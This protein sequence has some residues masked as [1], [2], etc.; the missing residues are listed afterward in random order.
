MYGYIISLNPF[1][2]IACFEYRTGIYSSI[3][4]LRFGKF[5]KQMHKKPINPEDPLQ[6]AHMTKNLKMLLM[7]HFSFRLYIRF[8]NKRQTHLY[9]N[10]HKCT[11]NQ[12]LARRFECV[13]LDRLKGYTDLINL[14]ERSYQGKYQYATIYMRTNGTNEFNE[15]CRQY[16]TKGELSFVND[17]VIDE[18]NQYLKLFYTIQNGRVEIHTT[19]PQ[20]IDFKTIL[21]QKLNDK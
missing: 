18:T 17:P 1:S 12:L 2:S 11:Y 7:P 5:F 15:V 8:N 3:S 19:D 4:R 6:Q 21:N 16:N 9:G 14:I 13:Q 10:E 20:A